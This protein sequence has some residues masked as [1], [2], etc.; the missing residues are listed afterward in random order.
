MRNE[1]FDEELSKVSLHRFHLLEL[2]SASFD[3]FPSFGPCLVKSQKTA[4]A[5]TLNQLIWFGHEFG[6]WCKQPWICG[7][8]LVEYA[9]DIGVLGKV[10]RGKFRGGIVF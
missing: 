5:T 10:E 4:L 1:W 7:L 3:P 2:P 6:A 9:L 8:G